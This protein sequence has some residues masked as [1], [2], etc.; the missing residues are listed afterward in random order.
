MTCQ[1]TANNPI[2]VAHIRGYIQ[3]K[4][5]AGNAMG[6]HFDTNGRQ[7]SSPG[8]NPGEALNPTGLHPELGHCQDENLLQLAQVAN[9][10]SLWQL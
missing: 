8:P 3:S 7:L 4:A 10:I 1:A 9:I 2:P 6:I 5:M